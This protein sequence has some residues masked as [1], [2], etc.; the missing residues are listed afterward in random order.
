A[1]VAAVSGPVTLVRARRRI[2]DDDAL[3]G[4]AVGDVDFVRRVV[5]GDVNRMIQIRR[6]LFVA[7]LTGRADLENERAGRR[8]FQHLRVLRTRRRGIA[9]AAA[10]SAAALR[11]GRPNSVSLLINRAAAACAAAARCRDRFRHAGRRDPNIALRINVD[12]A[13]RDGPVKSLS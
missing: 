12:A 13:S 7:E 1:E 8:K 5:D 9:T 3:A 11:P 6:T 4:A 10:T 2:E